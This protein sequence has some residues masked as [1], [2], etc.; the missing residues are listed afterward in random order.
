MHVPGMK[1]RVADATSRFP[2]ATDPKEFS[3]AAL[4]KTGEVQRISTG[5]LTGGRRR[6]HLNSTSETE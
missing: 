5:L 6:P 3:I 2:T 4:Q 1:N